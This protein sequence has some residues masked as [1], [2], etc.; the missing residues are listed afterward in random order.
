MLSRKTTSQR[1]SVNSEYKPHFVIQ[2]VLV[3]YVFMATNERFD[4]NASS[5]LLNSVPNLLR[6]VLGHFKS[7]TFI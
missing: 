2:A 1:K 5:S 6:S 4:S 3:F 7:Y